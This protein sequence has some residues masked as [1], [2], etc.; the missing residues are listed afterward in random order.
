SLILLQQYQLQQ[1]QRQQHQ[2]EQHNIQTGHSH[3]EHARQ[4]LA[5]AS[6]HS[7]QQHFPSQKLK[8]LQQQQQQLQL[9][10]QKW[11]S[12]SRASSDPLLSPTLTAS[13]SG[14]SSPQFDTASLSSPVTTPATIASTSASPS[15]SASYYKRRT[16]AT[17]RSSF[18]APPLC[19]FEI[20]GFAPDDFLSQH[21]GDDS[22]IEFDQHQ[23]QKRERFQSLDNEEQ[24]NE[25][26]S[27]HGKHTF[28][29]NQ[30][31]SSPGCTSTASVSFNG[32]SLLTDTE[33]GSKDVAMEIN[34]TKRN[35]E[36]DSNDADDA[37]TE[38]GR[39]M[40]PTN[41]SGIEGARP[42]NLL[43]AP[44][45]WARVQDDVGH[46]ARQQTQ[47]L[48]KLQEHLS[49]QLQNQQEHQ[50]IHCSVNKGE[51]DYSPHPHSRPRLDLDLPISTLSLSSHGSENTE[52][53]SDEDNDGKGEA[54]HIL[55]K[56][57]EDTDTTDVVKSC[58]SK[59]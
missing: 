26:G 32:E 45:E 36:S 18:S 29:Y 25:L 28:E 30:E 37:S 53:E 51:K 21:V 9:Q 4:L 52:V 44:E 55:K 17:F 1:I 46:V 22:E 11:F 58:I 12:G 47:Q 54:V 27:E 57:C 24:D 2:Q 48:K 7:E 8:L 23:Q 59:I 40:Y 33:V 39:E 49:Q 13:A 42:G 6:Q 35:E 50:P 5:Q 10:Q 38:W 20:F 56:R 34:P 14:S 16:S 3:V 15:P 31:K 41:A 43:S 19:S